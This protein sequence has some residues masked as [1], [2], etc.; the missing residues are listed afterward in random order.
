MY[1]NVPVRSFRSIDNLLAS[2]GP[3]ADLARRAAAQS[4]LLEAVRAALPAELAGHCLAAALEQ[5]T[6]LLL[7]SNGPWA[8]RLRFQEPALLACLAR[9][10]GLEARRL[11][12]RAA[13]HTTAER[14]GRH[15]MPRRDIS[16]RSRKL[17]RETADVIRDPELAA[18]LRRLADGQKR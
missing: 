8:T 2:G 9:E 18:A 10:F 14:H 3:A 6:L 16:S 4:R 12:C 5:D 17:I 7:V 11:V 13:R 15:E 1:R